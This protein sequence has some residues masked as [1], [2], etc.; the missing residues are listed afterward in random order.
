MA[1]EEQQAEKKKAGLVRRIFKWIGLVVVSVLLIGAIIFQAPWKVTTLLV[2]ILAACTILPRP[3]RKWFWLSAVGVVVVLII[4]VFLP[5]SD[6]G[7]WRSYKYNFDEELEAMEVVH[8][9]P[10]E[11]NAATIY[12]ELLQDYDSNE[13]DLATFGTDVYDSIYREPWLSR[14]YPDVAEWFKGHQGIIS[15]LIEASKIEKC[16]FAISDPTNIEQQIDRNAAMRRWA[17]LL[18][19]ESNNDIGE[20]RTDQALEKCIALLSIAKHTYQQPTCLDLLVGIAIESLSYRQLNWLMVKGEIT[21]EHLNV[22]EEALSNAGYD[23]SK[24]FP[25]ILKYEKLVGKN[26]LASAYEVN[27]EGTIRLS[28]DPLAEMRAA[29]KEKL[30]SEKIEPQKLRE[31][32]EAI[33]YIT[34]WQKKVL[35]AKTILNWFFL[36]SSPQGGADIIDASYERMYEMAEPDFDWQKGPRGFSL[37]SA[38]LNFRYMIEMLLYLSESAYY[39]IHEIH[40]RTISQKRGGR[41]IVGLRRYKNREGRWPESLDEL[42]PLVPAEVLVDPIN[43]GTFVY[44]LT[45][46]NFTLYSKGKNNIDEGGERDDEAEKD[47]RLIWPT[48][49]RG[50]ADEENEDEEQQ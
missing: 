21:E 34:Y 14:D 31:A 42:E 27:P 30:E 23:W 6:T 32:F 24:G 5:E 11:E 50:K 22:I 18:T 3:Y 1:E 20:G 29:Y 12:N 41:I 16:R 7:E 19:G 48:R 28:R 4:W 46:E 8:R 10:G 15:K 26:E 49:R 33:A 17:Y 39:G 36:P 9:I 45:E 13:L 47:D 35:K 40:V 2:I 25:R 37:T 44:K 38:K 43:N